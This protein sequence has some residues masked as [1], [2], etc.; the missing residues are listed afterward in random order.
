MAKIRNSSKNPITL[1]HLPEDR[2]KTHTTLVT[3]DGQYI[4]VEKETVIRTVMGTTIVPGSTRSQ[5]GEITLT[6]AEFAKI[7]PKALAC[8]DAVLTVT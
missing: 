2:V 4:P 3:I 1:S 7:D 6:K 5:V 8:F